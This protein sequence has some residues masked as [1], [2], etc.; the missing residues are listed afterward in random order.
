MLYG[1][2]PRMPTDKE[3]VAQHPQDPAAYKETLPAMLKD[4]WEKA[5]EIMK[6][7]A[8]NTKLMFDTRQKEVEYNVGDKVYIL[9]PTKVD[10]GMTTK[11]LPRWK[12]PCEVIERMNDLN[13]RVKNLVD[14]KEE[15]V[16]VQHMTIYMPWSDETFRVLVQKAK[17]KR[18]E[19]KKNKPAKKASREQE[20]KSDDSD[21]DDED[22]Y[23]SLQS[24]DATISTD[25]EK[26]QF[27]IVVTEPTPSWPHKWSLAKVQSVAKGRKK[28]TVQWYGTYTASKPWSS[29]MLPGWIDYRD[30]RPYFRSRPT[31]TK[32]DKK[33]ISEIQMEQ[34]QVWG[35]THVEKARYL[36][37]AVQKLVEECESERNEVNVIQRSVYRHEKWTTA[38][39]NHV[40]SFGSDSEQAMLT[41]QAVLQFIY[42]R[43]EFLKWSHLNQC[44]P[45]LQ[46][47]HIGWMIHPTNETVERFRQHFVPQLRDARL[48]KKQL[49]DMLCH[50]YFVLQSKDGCFPYWVAKGNLS[51][52][53]ISLFM[54]QFE[55]EDSVV[56]SG[57]T[58]LTLIGSN[59]NMRRKGGLEGPT[60]LIRKGE[61]LL[62]TQHTPAHADKQGASGL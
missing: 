41:W 20:E 31:S 52:N 18:Q 3:F 22:Q 48:V 21:S 2:E 57:P 6:K 62:M 35:I 14:D 16:H 33:W 50:R 28:L 39:N 44:K 32:H 7:S 15:T 43:N 58:M 30:D 27:V 34:V 45:D 9:R 53:Q 10:E 11:F 19:K 5:T 25:I 59:V 42:D 12:G 47:N 36:G 61:A 49:I 17:E 46:D 4:V 24:G 54:Y 60:R 23:P 38:D 37:S 29:E 40:R 13:Y 51:N 1:R 26:D 8:D 55:F 56:Q